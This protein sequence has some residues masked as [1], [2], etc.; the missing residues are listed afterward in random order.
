[1]SNTFQNTT[2]TMEVFIPE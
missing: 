2:F 1:M